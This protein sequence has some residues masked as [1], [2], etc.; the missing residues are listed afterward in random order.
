[1]NYEILEII[2]RLKKGV[3]I[4]IHDIFLPLQYP[5]D[6]VK[7]RHIFWTEQYLVQAFNRDFEI[8]WSAGYMH[9]NMSKM[10]TEYF[11]YYDSNKQDAGSFWIRRCK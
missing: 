3:L 8:V 2:P 1:M 6:W 4:H 5:K 10:L 11:P 9:V 7:N